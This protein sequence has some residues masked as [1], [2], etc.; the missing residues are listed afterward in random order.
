MSD[1]IE[2]IRH[3]YVKFL[4]IFI[5]AL[6]DRS[7]HFHHDFELLVVLY[8]QATLHTQGETLTLQPNDIFLLN[9]NETHEI[10]TTE[11][12]ITLLCIQFSPKFFENFFPSLKTLLFEE[13]LLNSILSKEQQRSIQTLAIESSY[14]YLKQEPN[15]HL[16]SS[17]LLGILVSTLINHVPWHIY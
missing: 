9:P 7:P 4:N 8:G 16:L 14:I 11:E 13:R 5:V 17:S 6:T 12:G 3:P 15:A 1:K 2:I 10:H